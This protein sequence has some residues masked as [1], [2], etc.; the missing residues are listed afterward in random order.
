MAADGG[1]APYGEHFVRVG[2]TWADAAPPLRSPEAVPQLDVD[3]D[4]YERR[5]TQVESAGGPYSDGLTEPLLGLAR[6]HR[7]QGELE[8]ALALYQRALHLLRVNDGLYSERQI[9]LVREQ[10]QLYREAGDFKALDQRYD[11]FFRL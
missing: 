2:K 11:Y 1:A 6:Y 5:L 8:T 4:V 7:G 9:P 3:R 10:L